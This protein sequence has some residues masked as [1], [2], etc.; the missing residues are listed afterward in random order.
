MVTLIKNFLS[1]GGRLSTYFF[2]IK[3]WMSVAVKTKPCPLDSGYFSD[4]NF[5]LYHASLE[6]EK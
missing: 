2:Y 5:T 1:F 3:F 6:I 4:N